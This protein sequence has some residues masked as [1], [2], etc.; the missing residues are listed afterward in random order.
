[1]SNVAFIG[2]GNM[3]SGMCANLVKAGHSVKAFDLNPQAI[4]QAINSGATGAE[5]I[6]DCVTEAE[7]VITM[8]PAGKHVHSVYFD[9]DGITSH[10]LK[11]AV[12]IDCSTIAVSEAR[13][14]ATQA[15][16]LGYAV[17]DAPVSGGVAAANA[18]TLTFMVGGSA[19]AQVEGLL[20]N[21]GQNIFHAGVSGNGQ[22]AKTANNMLL[23]I[24]MIATSEAF[25]LAEKLGLSAEKFFEISSKASGQC[26]SMTS[27]CPAPGP[28]PTSPANNDYTAGFAVAMM[29]KDLKLAQDAGQ[30]VDAATPL[31]QQATAIYQDLDNAGLTAKDFSV[32]MQQIKGEL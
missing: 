31:G 30:S 5:S 19:F 26:W 32:V 16:A 14:I 24:S 1:M 23:G 8:L 17:V 6:A 2:L 9:Q 11:S 12:L 25:N 28:V 13:D 22:A 20:G 27:Y 10:A 15:A 4:E 29:L 21:M 3:G 18:G 7:Y